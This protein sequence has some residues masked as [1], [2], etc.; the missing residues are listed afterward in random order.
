MKTYLTFFFLL[1][2][3]TAFT[4]NNLFDFL[5]G[6]WKMEDK[7]IYEHWDKMNDNSMKGVSYAVDNKKIIVF[8]YLDLFRNNDTVIY[9]AT[10]VGQNEGVGIAF[11]MT[12]SDSIF[13][14]ENPRHDFPKIIT[15][16]KVADDE[17]IVKISDGAELDAPITNRREQEFSWVMRK[18]Y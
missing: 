3:H 4:Q 6:T 17:M 9:T 1:L 13:F 8:E 10:V 11:I 12:R 5:Q 2:F 15:Y 7:E 14:F 18:V 16:Q